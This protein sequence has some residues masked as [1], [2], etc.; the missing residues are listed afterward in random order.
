[1]DSLCHWVRAY[2][3]P[4]YSSCRPLQVAFFELLLACSG[5]WVHLSWRHEWEAVLGLSSGYCCGVV[6]V[7]VC[8]V[9]GGRLFWW[10][11]WEDVLGLCCGCCFDV[12]ERGGVLLV[13]VGGLV[14]WRK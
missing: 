8:H 9:W 14:G 2:R 3:C 5:W 11:V 1:M 13:V 6:Q 4:F 7:W 10:I 12:L